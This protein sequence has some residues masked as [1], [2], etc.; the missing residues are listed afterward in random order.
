MDPCGRRA[1]GSTSAWWWIA[2]VGTS[3]AIIAPLLATGLPPLLDYPN[4]LARIEVLARGADDPV[5]SRMYVTRWRI[6]PNIAIDVIAPPMLKLMSLAAAGRTVVAL[7][8]LLPF[9]GTVML[10]TALFHRRSFWPLSAALVS[11][12]QLLFL[13]FLNFLIGV[14]LA[15]MGAALYARALKRPIMRLAPAMLFAIVLFFCHLVALACY[16]LLLAAIELA[17][18]TEER[19]G[20]GMLALPSPARLIGAALPFVIPTFLYLAAPLAAE[21]AALYWSPREKLLGVLAGFTTYS[22]VLDIAALA[23]AVVTI[24][25]CWRTARLSVARALVIAL[26]ALVGVYALA[27]FAAKGTGFLDQRLP[28]LA[29]FLLFAGTVPIG[30]SRRH[31]LVVSLGIIAIVS[32]RLLDISSVWNR[33]SEDVAAFRRVIAPIEPGSRVL[34]VMVTARD[35]P[36]FYEGQPRSRLFLL[37]HPGVGRAAIMHLPGLVLIERRAFWPLLF[38][39]PT[40]QPLRVLPPYSDIA[41]GEG[42]V[43]SYTWL[44]A[45]RETPLPADAPYLLDWES[46]FDYVIVLYAGKLP[47]GVP[48][49]PDVLE[50]VVAADVAALY[51]IKGAGASARPETRPERGSEPPAP[52][53]PVSHPVTPP[54]A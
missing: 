27:P 14:G 22:P 37:G 8:L 41:V 18:A 7:A 21:P 16:A 29:S 33:H 30:L 15:L 53:R 35:V 2:L 10:H 12:N 3:L 24:L 38:S 51:R 39:A 26:L 32:L 48:L 17:L 43:P 4:H 36:D 1:R 40:K 50:P 46:S 23:T 45:T 19:R 44:S 9:L 13:G 42:I 25:W 34:A 5:L 20:P 28:T 52:D 47:V 31:R 6:L 11:Y 54:G 49:R